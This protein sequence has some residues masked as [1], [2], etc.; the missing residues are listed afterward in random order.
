MICSK[1][2]N[3]PVKLSKYNHYDKSDDSFSDDNYPVSLPRALM[4]NFDVIS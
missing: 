4:N 3:V 1:C 2:A